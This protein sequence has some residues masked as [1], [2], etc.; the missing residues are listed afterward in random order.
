M[1]AQVVAASGAAAIKVAPLG[2]RSGISGR[3]CPVR[4]VVAAQPRGPAAGR[5]RRSSSSLH[6]LWTP[7]RQCGEPRR[8]RTRLA[9]REGSCGSSAWPRAPGRR[10]EIGAALWCCNRIFF[11][12]CNG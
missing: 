5:R 8:R 7:G 11:K 6:H 1:A 9:V 12:C 4:G 10:W 3:A 2:D